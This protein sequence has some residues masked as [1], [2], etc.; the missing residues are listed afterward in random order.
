MRC[1]SL[2]LWLLLLAALPA[3]ADSGPLE[4][5]AE[6]L[7]RTLPAGFTVFVEPPFVVAGDEAPATV[8]ERSRNT[9]R[10]A[11]DLLR[12]DFFAAEPRE[13][14]TI[15][16][17]RDRASYETHA[18][19]LFG[20]RPTTP[21]GYYTATHRALVMNIATGGGTLV[22][23]IV[24]PFMRANF[25]ACPAWLNEGLASL[26]EQCGEKDGHIE[27][28]T[29]WRL[30]GLQRVIAD[31]TLP[32]FKTLLAMDESTFYGPDSGAHYA[33]ARYLCYYLQEHGLLR[34]Y[35]R[36]FVVNHGADPSGVRT[37]ARILGGV[38]L[39]A[40]Q[41]Q[42]QEYVARLRFPR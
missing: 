8:R 12:K 38:D 22:H 20:S 33:Q 11:V 7:R 24:H 4:R 36:E 29:N 35:V 30:A 19:R 37:L 10:W 5:Q 41:A 27:G 28:Y 32:T 18:M 25:P 26:F 42:W 2:V 14:I 13:V 15:Y 9:I 1:A 6:H 17:F 31:G 21:Y 16:L 34:R 40:F 39:R 3:P 23:E